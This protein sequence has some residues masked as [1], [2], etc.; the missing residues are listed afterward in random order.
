MRAQRALAVGAGFA[1][2][3][4]AGLVWAGALGGFDNHAIHHWMPWARPPGEHRLVSLRSAFLPETR[5]T[6][7]GTLVGLWVY[8]ASP[9]LSLLIVL[10]CA[11]FLE[12]RAA[13]AVV[14]LWVVA[15][16]IEL[17]GKLT[18]TRPPVDIANLRDSFPSGHTVRALVLAA[19]LAWT[20]RRT[21]PVAVAWAL[22]VPF[23]LVALGDH[24]PTDVI[25]GALLAA[26]LILLTLSVISR[27]G[28]RRFR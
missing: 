24:V 26:C 9:F 10:L 15:N 18:I 13:F 22:T 19:G 12:R 20:W 21:G 11:R 6:L 7:G 23:A 5:S 2:L 27:T 28:V 25:G 17:A 3:A 16:A 8:P 14:A 4:L 1:F